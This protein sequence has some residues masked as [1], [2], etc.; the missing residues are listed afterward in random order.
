MLTDDFIAGYGAPIFTED[1]RVLRRRI[2][3]RLTRLLWDTYVGEVEYHKHEYMLHNRRVI[4]EMIN[5]LLADPIA[6]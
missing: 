5:E 1:T 3:C 2:L 6:P 4:R